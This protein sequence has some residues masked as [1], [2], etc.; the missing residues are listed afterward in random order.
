MD[1]I[2]EKLGLRKP[3]DKKVDSAAKPASTVT[4]NPQASRAI[5]RP[6]SEVDVVKQMEQLSGGNDNWKVSIVE[7]LTLLK[8]DSSREARNKLALELGC[9]SEL[10]DDSAQMNMWLHKAVLRKIALNGGNIP[11]SLL[12]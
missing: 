3:E 2:L 9:P 4:S 5:P 7:L 1:D 12:D 11:P 10:M 8:I 6:I